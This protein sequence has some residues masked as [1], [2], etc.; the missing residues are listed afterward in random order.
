MK[1]TLESDREDDGRWIAEAPEFPGVLVYGA[2]EKEAIA[3]AQALAA[4]VLAEE[5]AAE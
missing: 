5:V 1:L 4:R 3:K 2:T